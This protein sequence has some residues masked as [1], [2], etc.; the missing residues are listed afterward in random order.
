[1][2]PIRDLNPRQRDA[3]THVEGPL[4]VLAGAGSGKTRVLAHRIAFLLAASGAR[5]HQILA[6]TFTNKAAGEMRERVRGLVGD[7]FAGLWMGT[8]HSVCAKILRRDGRSLGVSP[9]FTIYD[10]QDQLALVKQIMAGMGLSLTRTSAAGML[11]RISWAKSHLLS[12]D[13]FEAATPHDRKTPDIYRSYEA[14]LRASNALDFDDLIAVP[15]RLLRGSSEAL[16]RAAGRFKYV[17]VDEYQD[18]NRAQYE[19]VRLVASRH[20]NI[21]VVGDD[22][23][24]IYR[25]RG[26]DVSNILNFERDFPDAKVVRLEQCYRS[27]KTI[28]AAAQAVIACNR[29]RKEKDLWTEN[30]VGRKI[31]LAFAG[32]EQD[33]GRLIAD[34]VESLARDEDRRYCDFVVLYRTNAQSRSIE[35]AMRRKG[36]PYVIVGGTKFYERREIKDV[37]G[38]LRLVA[39]PQDS[40]SLLRVINLPPRGIGDVTLARLKDFAAASSCSLLEAAERAGEIAT[41]QSGARGKLRTFA[42]LIRDLRAAAGATSLG[43]LV[44]LAADKSGYLE[45]LKQ[46]AT[47]EAVTRTENVRELVA[48]GFEFEERVEGATLEKFLEEI[49]LIMDID[50][51]D[52]RKEA[53]SLMT[54]HNAKG[55][56]FPVVFIAG[57]EEGLIPHHTSF[58]D[59]EEIEEERRLFYVGLTRARSQVV[60]SLAS[61]RR[62][63][64]GWVAQAA[65][66]FLE[67]IPQ[68]C[69]EILTTEYVSYGREDPG[70]DRG[71]VPDLDQVVKAGTRVRHHDWGIGRVARCEGFGDSLRLVVT[72]GPGLTKRIMAR[73]ANL[74]ILGEDDL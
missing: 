29:R 3:V 68:E 24:S 59:P 26:A 12:C 71:W 46:Q 30:E 57:V 60:I 22:D 16:E 65:S 33:E 55:L 21:C 4:L 44:G 6:L 61:G 37:I 7:I 14:A 38:Y 9:N 36:M 25:W 35:D 34:I 17:L 66:R 2:D 19:L 51:W 13:E 47:V 50:V 23:Q 63:F 5:P 40:V 11:G 20:R 28:L 32:G 45:H 10:E 42:G 18:T 74:E 31:G 48:S 15:V 53:V 41:I 72:F 70:E 69:L 1:V 73:Y 62:G 56:E 64:Q 58:E 39:N 49:S 27:T 8:F 52:D 43:E 67:E 54:L